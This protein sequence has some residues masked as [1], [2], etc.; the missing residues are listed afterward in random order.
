VKLVQ[1]DMQIFS[2]GFPH[3]DGVIR[4]DAKYSTNPAFLFLWCLGGTQLA[5]NLGVQTRSDIART[6]KTK[7]KM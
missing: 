7:K 6:K 5:N 1:T 2:S 3:N 4:K